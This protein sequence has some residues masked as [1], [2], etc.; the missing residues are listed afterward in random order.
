MS[1]CEMPTFFKCSEPTARKQHYCCECCAP[2]EV[3][4]KHIKAAG[5]WPDSGFSE[6]RQHLLLCRSLHVYQGRDKRQRV[7]RLRRAV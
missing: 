3:G 4:E 5:R 2:I 1:V 7:Q 6:Y